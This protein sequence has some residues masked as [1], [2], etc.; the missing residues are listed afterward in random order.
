MNDKTLSGDLTEISEKAKKV[1][2][3]IE[4]LDMVSL[5]LDAVA[6]VTCAL[7]WATE[8]Q[9][10][11]VEKAAGELADKH[12]SEI[13][14]LRQQLRGFCEVH[15]ADCGSCPCCEAVN[16]RAKLLQAEADRERLDWL[17]ETGKDITQHDKLP[18]RRWFVTGAC[19]LNI[20]AAIDQ[21][22]KKQ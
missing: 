19:Y 4:E 20:R 7:Q 15:D 17:D 11:A 10:S 21:E 5:S 14:Q 9:R 12:A 13:A 2:L 1:V 18:Y 6:E 8:Q 3:A 16:E 22:R